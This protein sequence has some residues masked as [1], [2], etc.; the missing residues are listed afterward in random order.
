MSESD[1]EN[2]KLQIRDDL[3]HIQNLADSSFINY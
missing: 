3:N 2:L 1:L